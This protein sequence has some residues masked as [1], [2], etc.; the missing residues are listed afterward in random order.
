MTAIEQ[1]KQ[2]ANNIALAG[3]VTFIVTGTIAVAGVVGSLA[4]SAGVVTIFVVT[5][6]VACAEAS[7]KATRKLNSFVNSICLKPKEKRSTQS[8]SY[9]DHDGL[10]LI[11]RDSSAMVLNS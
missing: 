11:P 6:A 4:L 5:P 8:F 3:K 1:G 2:I 9:E 10:A 7:K